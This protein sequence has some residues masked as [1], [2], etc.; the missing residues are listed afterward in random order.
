[1]DSQKM[2]RRI[3]ETED[4]NSIAPT[5]SD[6]LGQSPAAPAAADSNGIPIWKRILD[7]SCLL[8]TVP[9]LLPVMVVIAI[10]IKA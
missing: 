3:R 7:V 2:N 6:L 4:K 1:M 5:G 10:V 8:I 9:T